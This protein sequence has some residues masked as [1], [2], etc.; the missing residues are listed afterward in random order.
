MAISMFAMSIDGDGKYTHVSWK[1][2]FEVV[3]SPKEDVES[4]PAIDSGS[5]RKLRR[6]PILGRE[7]Y[8]S[9]IA[10]RDYQQSLPQVS[11]ER[12]D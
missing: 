11:A 1:N 10:P 7:A 5:R 9:G 2:F 6:V 8:E 4:F 3:S 12:P